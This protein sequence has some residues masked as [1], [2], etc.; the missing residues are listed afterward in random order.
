MPATIVGFRSPDLIQL[1][2]SM[3]AGYPVVHRAGMLLTS[4]LQHTGAKPVAERDVL[5][6]EREREPPYALSHITHGR[7]MTHCEAEFD[8]SNDKID[9]S[10]PRQ[11]CVRNH[12]KSARSN[13]GLQIEAGD[14]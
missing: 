10:I 6:R 2:L 3:R 14:R 8:D 9:V 7:R 11:P 1:V 12:G 5:L 13:S 4:N